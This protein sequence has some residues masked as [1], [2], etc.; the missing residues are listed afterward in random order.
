M[1]LDSNQRP[2]GPEARP[3]TPL[4]QAEKPKILGNSR[5]FTRLALRLQARLSTCERLREMPE[6]PQV[7]ESAS[8]ELRNLPQYRGL[9][10]RAEKGA[11][12]SEHPRGHAQRRTTRPAIGRIAPP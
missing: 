1:R 7:F 9:A 5:Y 8:R 11:G 4:S 2:R 12:D 10:T 3:D 6:F